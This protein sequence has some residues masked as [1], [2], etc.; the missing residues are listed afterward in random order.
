HLGV[1]L[2]D[3]E[4]QSID[5]EP[6]SWETLLSVGLNTLSGNWFNAAFGLIQGINL[7]LVFG[8]SNDGLLP[9]YIP[10]LYYDV[11][12][13][14]IP[15]GNGVSKINT[16]I[17]PGEIKEIIS[18]QNI[19]KSSMTPAAISIINTEGVMN[20]KVRGTAY[21]QLF[22]WDIP[23]PFDSEKQISIHDEVRNKVNAEIQKNLSRQDLDALTCGDRTH[24]EN[25]KCVPD[26]VIEEVAGIFDE[27][28]KQIDDL[29]K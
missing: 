3:V 25:G 26:N 19:Q 20:I 28:K 23:V 10:D 6:M 16:I 21:F 7:N 24:D 1:S 5:W 15:I 11:L 4:F 2:K 27:I 12:I 9:A 29:L 22:V 14:N 13:N 8:L 17:N 18:F